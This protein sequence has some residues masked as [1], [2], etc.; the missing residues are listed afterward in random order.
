MSTYRSSTTTSTS[1]RTS[2]SSRDSYTSSNVPPSRS[3]ASSLLREDDLA[4]SGL[5]ENYLQRREAATKYIQRAGS[6]EML[7]TLGRRREFEEE[8]KKKRRPIV[9]GAVNR[10]IYTERALDREKKRQ[11]FVEASKKEKEVQCT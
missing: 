4:A 8:E 3:K 7:R 1:T 9:K 5:T 2:Y 10:D 6:S 11:R